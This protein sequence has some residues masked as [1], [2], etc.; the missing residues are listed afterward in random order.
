MI[1]FAG[2]GTGAGYMGGAGQ[3]WTGSTTLVIINNKQLSG[4]KTWSR[5]CGSVVA[6]PA[7]NVNS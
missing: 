1:F 5:C 4:L 2:A 3:D 6:C 7:L